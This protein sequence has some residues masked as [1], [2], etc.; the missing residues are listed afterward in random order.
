MRIEIGQKLLFLGEPQTGKTTLANAILGKYPSAI[1]FDPTG[2]FSPA[3]GWQVATSLEAAAKLTGRISYRPPIL[4]QKNALAHIEALGQICLNKKDTWLIIDEPWHGIK[5]HTQASEA[6]NLNQI[7]RE[8]H[9]PYNRVG[10]AVMTHRFTDLPTWLRMNHHTFVFNIR[11][12]RD[13]RT[14]SDF[15]GGGDYDPKNLPLYHFFHL[16]RDQPD[17]VTKY[18]PIE[19]K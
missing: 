14:V 12:V 10:L 2:F 6:Y 13:R 15:L 18:M 19:V 4:D 9:K 3:K 11:S 7:V 16:D 5:L 17:R 8:G 1:A